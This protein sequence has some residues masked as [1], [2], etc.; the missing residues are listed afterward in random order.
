M[1]VHPAPETLWLFNSLHVTALV[2]TA[3]LNFQ[4]CGLAAA[5]THQ[6]SLRVAP[7]I[8]RHVFSSGLSNEQRANNEGEIAATLAQVDA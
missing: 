7:R 1:R 6:M 3:A 8:G 2:L 5:V 4:E